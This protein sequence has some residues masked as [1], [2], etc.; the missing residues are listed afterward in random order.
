VGGDGKRPLGRTRLR[1]ENNIK[2]DL[3]DVRWECMGRFH[4]KQDRDRWQAIV[5]VVMILRVP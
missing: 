5:N 3:Y 1:L 4:L 2:M